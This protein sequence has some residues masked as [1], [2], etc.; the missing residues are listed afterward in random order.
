MVAAIAKW[1]YAQVELGD[2]SPGLRVTI[3]FRK[4]LP[5]SNAPP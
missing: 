3:K 2:S 1:H 5:F 4:E